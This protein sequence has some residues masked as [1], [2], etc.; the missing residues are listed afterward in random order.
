MQGTLDLWREEQ[1]NQRDQALERLER[2]RAELIEIARTVAITL[3]A[4]NGRVTSTE[5][6]AALRDQGYGVWIDSVDKRFMGAVFRP[7]SGWVRVGWEHTGSH[8]R[9][10]AIW[11]ME[12]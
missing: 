1:F 6:L 3:W 11:K 12:D 2:S 9:P 10:V 5:V 4:M 7:K 8:G